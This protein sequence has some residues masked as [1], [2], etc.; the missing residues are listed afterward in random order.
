MPE[1]RGRCDRCGAFL[2]RSRRRHEGLCGCCAVIEGV[3]WPARRRLKRRERILRRAFKMMLVGRDSVPISIADHGSD[4]E[5][6]Q[7]Q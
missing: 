6:A 2:A 4:R 1:W 3:A 5:T 7:R